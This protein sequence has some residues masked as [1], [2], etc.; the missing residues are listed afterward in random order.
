MIDDFNKRL[1]VFLSSCPTGGKSDYRVRI[2]GFL[3][4]TVFYKFGQSFQF[5]VLNFAEYLVCRGI[6][7]QL[8][9]LISESGTDFVCGSYRRFTYAQIE[10]IGEQFIKLQPEYTPFCKKR[11]VLLDYRKEMRN[12]AVLRDNH[13]L[14]KQR[15]ALGT[16]D[17]ECISEFSEIFKGDVIFGT[18]EGV[19]KSCAVKVQR[20]SCRAAHLA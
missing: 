9:S 3:P 7:A 8:K 11:A 16:A 1:R 10:I 13:C 2:I 4:E 14:T 12:I 20:N 5:T 6:K 19:C 18:G 17:V 15:S